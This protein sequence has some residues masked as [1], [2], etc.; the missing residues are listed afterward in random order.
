[1]FSLTD[2][3]ELLTLILG[4]WPFPFI[5]SDSRDKVWGFF[6]TLVSE[7]GHISLVLGSGI[8][9][10]QVLSTKSASFTG[11]GFRV[12][13][14]SDWLVSCFCCLFYPRD[15]LSNVVVPICRQ[16]LFA[17]CTPP[18]PR[19]KHTESVL[20]KTSLGQSLKHIASDYILS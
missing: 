18:Q 7:S 9:M 10:A 14:L 20:I 15:V 8:K 6:W 13:V 3:F 12:R 16:R 4:P 17:C 5:G 19:N 1:M 2:S 11:C